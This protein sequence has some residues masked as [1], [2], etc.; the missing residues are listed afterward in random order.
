[1]R[2]AL[3]I[4]LTI[5][6]VFYGVQIFI[7]FKSRTR[8]EVSEV[9]KLYLNG[10]E[11]SVLIEGKKREL[12]ILIVLH[13]GP[14]LPFPFGMDSRGLHKELTDQFITVYW[15]QFGCG[16]NYKELDHSFSIR[17]YQ[18]MLEDLIDQ[19]RVKYPT[20]EVYLLGL[21]WGSVLALNAAV[22]IEDKVSGVLTCGQ[23]INQKENH[24]INIDALETIKLKQKDLEIFDK[25]KNE[26]SFES[27]VKLDKLISKYTNG[28]TYNEKDASNSIYAKLLLKVLFS[29]DYNL[30][31]FLRAQNGQE[32][33]QNNTHILSEIDGLDL[34]DSLKQVKVPYTIVQG[35]CD[36]ITSTELVKDSLKDLDNI[37]YVE[38]EKSGHLPSNEDFNVLIQEIIKRFKK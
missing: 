29:P 4:I 2:I 23:F 25:I 5:V 7:L 9:Y 36:L 18:N 32:N 28:V 37:N 20:D 22:Q 24:K 34:R 10:E 38:L 12:P 26:D 31:D 8:N 1:M 17:T 27:K 19:M 11:Q 21:S 33:T 15:D 3:L 13:G 30:K 6:L 16:K 35:K 14:G